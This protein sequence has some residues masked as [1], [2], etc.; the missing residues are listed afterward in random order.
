M[1]A[2]GA[3]TL[4]VLA[5][6]VGIIIF[7]ARGISVSPSAALPSSGS[8]TLNL[9]GNNYACTMKGGVM[10]CTYRQP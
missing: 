1:S 8:F 2:K 10:N 5:L 3:R 7:A 6:A 9:D 4:L